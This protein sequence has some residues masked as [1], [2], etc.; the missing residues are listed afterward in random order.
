MVL[1]S[2]PWPACLTLPTSSF[3]FEPL[4]SSHT[5]TTSPP[6]PL[7]SHYLPL[8]NSRSPS[9]PT[10]ST[11]SVQSIPSPAHPASKIPPPISPLFHFG[12]DPAHALTA[13]SL[14]S[15]VVVTQS[16]YPSGSQQLHSDQNSFDL[17]L[18][19]PSRTSSACTPSL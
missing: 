15:S 16:R 6:L 18:N 8:R 7:P 11:T 14:A 9:N 2:L 4:H 5:R 1:P 3:A 17:L 12:N 10:S 13:S 19:C